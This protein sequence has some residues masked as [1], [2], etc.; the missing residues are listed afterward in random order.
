MGGHEDGLFREPIY[1]NKDGGI[2]RREWKLFNEVHDGDGIPRMR[3]NG[4]LL[5]C[6]IGFVM[7]GFSTRAGSTRLDVV[8]NERTN[9]W[10]CI[11]AL[12]K[13]KSV[14]LTEM[15]RERVVVEIAHDAQM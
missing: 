13:L 6:P 3:G 2:A 7:W 14:I 8:L 12:D 9:T 10:P 1:D 5:E 15:A 4:K 11:L